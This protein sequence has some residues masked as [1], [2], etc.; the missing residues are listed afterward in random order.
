MQILMMLID[1]GMMITAVWALVDCV[2]RPSDAF[3]A[4]DRQSKNLW[5]GILIASVIVQLLFNPLGLLPI[6]GLIASIVYLVDVRAKITEL[7]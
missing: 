5:L 6:A 7:V 1:L 4:V 2:Q 3:R